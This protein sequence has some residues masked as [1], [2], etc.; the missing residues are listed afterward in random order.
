MG[1]SESEVEE[2]FDPTTQSKYNKTVFDNSLEGKWPIPKNKPMFQAVVRQIESELSKQGLDKKRFAT[3]NVKLK[4]FQTKL[5]GIFAKEQLAVAAAAKAKEASIAPREP[6]NSAGGGPEDADG[7]TEPSAQDVRIRVRQ[8]AI[9]TAEE[10]AAIK[11]AEEEAAIEA[12]QAAAAAAGGLADYDAAAAAGA[13]LHKGVWPH[14]K[15]HPD[16]ALL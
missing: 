4:L 6:S 14:P 15:A 13:K 2:D 16:F 1:E 11:T 7:N 9:K 5:E 8:A 10:A 3:L 12:A